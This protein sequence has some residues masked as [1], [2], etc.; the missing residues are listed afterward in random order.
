MRNVVLEFNSNGNSKQKEC[1]KAWANDDVDEVLYGGAKGGGKSFIGC[2]L[3]FADAFMYP[4]TQYFI[5]RKQLNDLRRFTI[6]SIHEVLNSWSIPQEAYK[7]NGQDNYFELFNGSRVLLLDCR[8]LP[9]DPQYQRLGSMQFT[10]GWIEEGGEFDYDSYSN[11]KI[12]IGRWKNREYNLKG[13]LLI[14][15]NP[16]K[17]FLYKNFYKPYKSG[18]LERWKAFIQALPYDNKMLPKEY[19]ESLERTLKGAEK[20]R[21]LHGLWEYDDDPTALCDYDKI[22]AIFE[23]D[24]IPIDKEM[25]LSADIARFGSDLCVIGVW[26]GWELI[27]VHTLAISAM[28]EVQGLIHTLRMRYNIPKGNC[29]ADED[30]VG[31]GV[32]DNT[33]IVGFKNNSSPLDENGQA[34]SYKNLQTQCLY[35]L[36]ERINNNGIYISAELSEKTK[37]RIIEELEQI[38]SDNKDGQRLSVI[39]KD[40]IKQNIG[41]SPDYR[42]M[43]LMRE[44]F[45]LKPKKTFKPIFR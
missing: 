20:Q 32:V 9:S 15:A 40:T 3:I 28:T 13:K 17:N 24:Q 18:T 26:R 5:A 22:L 2:S 33:G 30:G 37:E 43:I 12:S 1:G 31:G 36:A 10:R 14:T 29:I 41:R 38:K 44:Y 19:I 21:L 39:N 42:D 8:Y 23:N 25:F 35:K 45:D 7:Y 34:T 27:E 4:N 16:S 11:L 6:P